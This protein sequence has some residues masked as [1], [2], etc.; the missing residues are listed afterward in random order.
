M[1]QPRAFYIHV[2]LATGRGLCVR[3]DVADIAGGVACRAPVAHGRTRSR[4]NLTRKALSDERESE[5]R[6]GR[7]ISHP[8]Y[9]LLALRYYYVSL[10]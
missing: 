1:P 6:K 7:L 10:H 8:I 5:I 2:Y 4:K 3:S 9:L